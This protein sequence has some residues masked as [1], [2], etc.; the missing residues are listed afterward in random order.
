[1]HR[2]VYLVSR[3]LTRGRDVAT[4]MLQRAS[5]P[6]GWLV[7]LIT[8]TVALRMLPT[9]PGPIASQQPVRWIDSRRGHPL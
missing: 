4:D 1:M 8:L 6:M 3:R 7:P 2:L 9:V 5:A